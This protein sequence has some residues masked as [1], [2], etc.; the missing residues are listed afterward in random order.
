MPAMIRQSPEVAGTL[1]LEGAPLAAAVAFVQTDANAKCG[2]SSLRAV[3]DERGYFSIPVDR[4]FEWY[5]LVPLGDR[6]YG[7]RLC[8]E[9]QGRSF[10]GYDGMSKHIPPKQIRLECELSPQKNGA[11]ETPRSPFAC[12]RRES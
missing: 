10:Q 1:T 11:E 3:T 12:K 9:Y 6:V 4:S 7:W 5:W 8:F 2:E